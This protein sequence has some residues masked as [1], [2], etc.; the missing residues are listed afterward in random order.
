MLVT[1]Q[2]D[3]RTLEKYKREA[4]KNNRESWELSYIMGKFITYFN[5]TQTIQ[6]IMFH[7]ML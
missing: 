2:V 1:G 6:S 7:P 4:K 5:L 3:A